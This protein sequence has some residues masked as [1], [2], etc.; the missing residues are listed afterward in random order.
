MLAEYTLAPASFTIIYSSFVSTSFISSTI[1]ASDSLEAVPFPSEIRLILYFFISSFNTFFDSATLFCGAVGKITF[2]SSTFPVSSTTAS[3]H[4]VLKAG[5]QP[6]TTLPATGGCIKSCVRF[7]PNT[8]MASSSAFS[9]RL[10]LISLSIEG[11]ISLLYA[12]SIV[13][14]SICSVCT[15]C[16]FIMHFSRYLIISSTGGSSFTVSI[17]SSSPL[18]IASIL[19]PA[20]FETLSAKL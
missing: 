5:S 8:L 12:S 7:F 2:V 14:L 13:S 16:F 17:F 6:S 20:V 18:L 10:D 19:Y 3:L 11:A 15:L 1:T 4:P 9:V